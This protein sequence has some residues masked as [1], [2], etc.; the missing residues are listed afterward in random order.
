MTSERVA[1]VDDIAIGSAIKVE[2]SGEPIALVRTADDTVKAVHNICSHQY[3]D[4]AP[5]GCIGDNSIECALHGSTLDLDTG[6]AESLPAVDPIPVYACRIEEGAVWVEAT[7]SPTT[8]RFPDTDGDTAKG[9]TSSALRPGSSTV[10]AFHDEFAAHLSR[11]CPSTAHGR[12]QDRGPQPG[13]GAVALNREYDRTA[14]AT[15]GRE[16]LGLAR[17]HRRAA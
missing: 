3:Y 9:P 13:N 8:P 17:T 14:G 16:S 1:S 4:L 5:E 6:A 15:A 7:S 12:A 10:D 11:P 2:I